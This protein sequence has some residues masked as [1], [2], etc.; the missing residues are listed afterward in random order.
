[1]RTCLIIL[2]P[3]VFLLSGGTTDYTGTVGHSLGWSLG[4]SFRVISRFL[5]GSSKY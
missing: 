5:E 3:E 2:P 1:M 4:N